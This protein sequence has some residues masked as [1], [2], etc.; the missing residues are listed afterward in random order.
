ML[1][2]TSK[3]KVCSLAAKKE[4][5]FFH[6]FFGCGVEITVILWNVLESLDLFLPVNSLTVWCEHFYSWYNIKL[7]EYYCCRWAQ[8]KKII[9]WLFESICTHSLMQCL[10]WSPM[11]WGIFCLIVGNSCQTST[12]KTSQNLLETR[13]KCGKYND[14]L[15]SV[16]GNFLDV[17]FMDKIFSCKFNGSALQ[18]EVA[19]NILT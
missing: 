8:Q 11:W 6:E 4:N 1:P 3:T 18:Y 15:L 9:P 12:S 7:V 5:T 16:D 17:F 14:C 10:K 13:Y 2:R 19:L